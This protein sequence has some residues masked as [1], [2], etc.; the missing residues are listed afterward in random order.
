V[1]GPLVKGQGGSQRRPPLYPLAQLSGTE[2]LCNP[3][4]VWSGLAI[5]TLFLNR[6]GYSMM[7]VKGEKESTCA[8]V[9]LSREGQSSV[10]DALV[11]K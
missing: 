3:I 9:D 5:T 8:H 2:G 10:L 7:V 11:S 4:N 6:F 1:L